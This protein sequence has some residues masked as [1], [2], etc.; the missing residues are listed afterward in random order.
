MR[1]C[2]NGGRPFNL[3]RCRQLV[4]GADC[5]QASNVGATQCLVH[6]YVG[7]RWRGLFVDRSQVRMDDGVLRKLRL[8][9]RERHNVYHAG[10]LELAFLLCLAF[11]E[12][13]AGVFDGSDTASRD[14][15]NSLFSTS[16]VGGDCFGHLQQSKTRGAELRRLCDRIEYNQYDGMGWNAN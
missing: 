11:S 5:G 3:P 8:D 1:I 15:A 7:A 2:H 9:W 4:R 10:G 6:T 16:R 14:L 12:R 13:V